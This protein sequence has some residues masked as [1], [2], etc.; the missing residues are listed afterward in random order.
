M[1]YFDEFSNYLTRKVDAQVL[2]WK[3]KA[4]LRKQCIIGLIFIEHFIT[5]T[6]VMKQVNSESLKLQ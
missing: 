3:L 4:T 6:E 1:L 2:K 5:G